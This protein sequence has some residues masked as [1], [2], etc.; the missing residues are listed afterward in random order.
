MSDDDFPEEKKKVFFVFY[1]GTFIESEK[2]RRKKERKKEPARVF[3][4]LH[5]CNRM[6]KTPRYN[7]NNKEEKEK[8]IHR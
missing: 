4:M 8:D 1:F 5:R 6:T 7:D 2:E 3:Y